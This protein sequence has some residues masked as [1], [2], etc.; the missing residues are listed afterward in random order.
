V[1][2]QFYESEALDRFFYY[3]ETYAQGQG[4]AHWMPTVWFDGVEEKTG[5]WVDV[6]E[7]RSGYRDIIQAHQDLPTPLEMDFQVE[8]GT[9]ANTVTVHVQVVA[10]DIVYYSDLYLRLAIIESEIG[11]GGKTYNQVLR[12]YLPSPAG[13]SFSIADGDTFTHSEDFVID[14]AWEADN[15]HIVV[16]VQNDLD[17]IVVQ[18]MQDTINVP[19]PVVEDTPVS[20]RPQYCQLSQNYPN[21]FNANT[22]IRYQIPEDGR[23]ILKI[24]NALGQEVRTLVNRDQMAAGYSVVWD[25]RDD[26]GGDVAS[27]LYL[28]RLKAG[29]LSKT[30]KMVLLR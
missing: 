14:S 22:E 18:A 2:G 4:W 27:G 23:V 1:G 5:A 11:Y 25:G 7:G 20:G 13:I 6:Y 26:V 16:F 9:K 28:C 3:P 21:P 12:D 17:R 15:C 24:F 8:Y 29:D 19:T 10:T 30:I